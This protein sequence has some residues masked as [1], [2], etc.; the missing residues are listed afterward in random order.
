MDE[1]KALE[2]LKQYM[3][4]DLILLNKKEEAGEM[5]ITNDEAAALLYV[6]G[7]VGYRISPPCSSDE[8]F[9]YNIM[10]NIEGW[11]VVD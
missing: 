1:L 9:Y 7:Y 2:I 3:I 5:I 11:E 10:D 8:R 6:I 4:D